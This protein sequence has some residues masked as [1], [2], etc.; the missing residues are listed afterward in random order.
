MS[1]INDALKRVQK[2]SPSAASGPQLRRAEPSQIG[3]RTLSLM[4]PVLL[5]F[6]V[7][8]GV[9]FLWEAV[10]YPARNPEP[11]KAKT[12]VAENPEPAKADPV[13]VKTV[14]PEIPQSKVAQQPVQKTVQQPVQK[15][16]QRPIQRVVQQPVQK[17]VQQPAQKPV[18]RPVQMAMVSVPRPKA[19]A[20]KPAPAPVP[21]RTEAA[22]APE[23][24]PESVLPPLTPVRL[25]AIFYA[26]GR[27]TAIIN[28]K[29]M[30]VGET[31]NEYRL[32]AITQTSATLATTR[33]TN[34]LTLQ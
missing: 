6:A 18:Q 33:R 19:E 31:L 11:V 22:P 1:M 27:S 25:Q 34:V 5:V 26:P 12:L 29:T 32:M 21:Q 23:P 10:Q 16:M 3:N 4:V 24:A 15:V 17:V 9:F 13:K 28:G 30:R 8:I 20:P 14:V 7:L 2:K